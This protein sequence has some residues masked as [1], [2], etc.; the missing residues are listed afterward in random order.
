MKNHLKQILI[1][2]IAGMVFQAC[3]EEV[4][5][6]GP[7][8]PD[9]LRYEGSWKGI[10]AQTKLLSIQVQNTDSAALISECRIGYLEDGILKQRFLTATRG[11]S[12]IEEGAFNILLPDG[13]SVSGV[14]HSTDYCAGS[15]VIPGNVTGIPSE[16]QFELTTDTNPE[17]L[18]SPARIYF[19]IDG[20]AYEFVQD[21]IFYIPDWE[22]ISTGT[23]RL[24]KSHFT[25]LD[26]A[27]GARQPVITITAGRIL[28]MEGILT[29]FEPGQKKY[30]RYAV[31]G[32]EVIL[33]HPDEYYKDYSTSMYSGNQDGSHFE[34]KDV[35]TFG[36]N[37]KLYRLSATFNCRLYRPWGSPILLENGFFSGYI[38]TGSFQ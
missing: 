31:E 7:A 30:S 33:Y 24:V 18:L 27:T 8:N 15:I 3:E 29:A 13:G 2:V 16:Y 21:D 14:F 5:P 20:V 22:N 32:F 26:N 35:K 38:D 12:D 37:N 1:L 36:P 9:D 10:H 28:N 17:S 19:E 34:I 25:R 11:L 6:P 4:P 23:G